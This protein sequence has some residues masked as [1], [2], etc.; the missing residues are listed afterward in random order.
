M[1]IDTWIN[2]R[3]V[4]EEYNRKIVDWFRTSILE[5]INNYLEHRNL[6]ADDV[7]NISI[8]GGYFYVF[9]RTFE[10]KENDGVEKDKD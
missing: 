6:D 2:T 8:E 9:Y 5:N 7:I 10:V 3:F 4:V 1:E